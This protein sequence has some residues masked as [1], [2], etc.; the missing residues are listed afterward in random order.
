MNYQEFDELLHC[1][2]KYMNKDVVRFKEAIFELSTIDM[3]NDMG[4][5]SDINRR[6]QLFN[7]LT[8]GLS[9][10]D[11]NTNKF[12]KILSNL[13]LREKLISILDVHIEYTGTNYDSKKYLAIK[14]DIYYK[15]FKLL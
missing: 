2:V 12:D 9:F 6:K 13:N 8:E 7:I 4:I 11:T 14:N 10:S 15:Y 1:T 3:L 5:M